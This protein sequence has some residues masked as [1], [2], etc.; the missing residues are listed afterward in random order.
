M[1]PKYLSWIAF[2]LIIVAIVLFEDSS[3]SKKMI[4]IACAF[5]GAAFITKMD[6]D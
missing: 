1:K 2:A 5:L 4:G 3:I 6:E